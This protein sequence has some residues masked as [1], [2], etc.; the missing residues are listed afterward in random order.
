MEG[1][2]L[3]ALPLRVVFVWLLKTPMTH[4]PHTF[5]IWVR[6]AGWGQTRMEPLGIIVFSCIMG[7]AGFSIIL[8]GCQQLVAGRRTELP[9]LWIVVGGA[10][11]QN[12]GSS[13][14]VG[15]EG[16]ACMLL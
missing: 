14:R 1:I 6:L 12:V 8:E 9:S 3:G 16:P 2:Q 10:P 13:V 11:R 7:S 15:V 4:N 5:T